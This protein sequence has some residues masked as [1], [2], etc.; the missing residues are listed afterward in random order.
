MIPILFRNSI[1]HPIQ[2]YN[3][4]SYNNQVY[5]PNVV[6]DYQLKIIAICLVVQPIVNLLALFNVFNFSDENDFFL[7]YNLF[8]LTFMGIIIP[9]LVYIFNP[10][11]RIFYVRIFWEVAPNW[12]QQFNPDRVIEVNI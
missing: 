8:R 10:H 7:A 3:I 12:F 9:T 11:I 2:G 4:G 1:N 6:N 5:N